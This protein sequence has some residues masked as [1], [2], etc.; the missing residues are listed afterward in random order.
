MKLVF[1][2]NSFRIKNA[3]NVL[4]NK[5]AIINRLEK[6]RK[7]PL[8]FMDTINEMVIDKRMWLTSLTTKGTSINI[9]GIA[10]DN[11]T[12]A[13]FMTRLEASKLFT[14]V[15]LKSVNHKKIKK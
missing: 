4:K 11:K 6:D 8:T 13:D 5:T 10:L 14:A 7:W 3:L 9:D 1:G 15:N 2:R 12:V